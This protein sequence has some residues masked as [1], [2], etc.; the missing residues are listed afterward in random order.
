M[1]LKCGKSLFSDRWIDIEKNTKNNGSLSQELQSTPSP[2]CQ[3]KGICH[4]IC[5]AKWAIKQLARRF[6]GISATVR[7]PY[8]RASILSIDC[9]ENPLHFGT[10]CLLGKGVERQKIPA[11]RP[12]LRIPCS[13][14]R[15]NHCS[16]KF[17]CLLEKTYFKRIH[18]LMWWVQEYPLVKKLD[19]LMPI[20]VTVTNSGRIELPEIIKNVTIYTSS[21]KIKFLSLPFFTWAVTS[22][23]RCSLVK[24]KTP[25][26]MVITWRVYS[27]LSKII[28]NW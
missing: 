25:N 3:R 19:D 20:N 14:L 8:K 26:C 1:Q 23:P 21:F 28:K 11:R 22:Y 10:S 4:G 16:L 5:I 24:H 7:T 18:I 13:Q 27:G 17:F 9:V 2:P 15:T 6:I 12:K